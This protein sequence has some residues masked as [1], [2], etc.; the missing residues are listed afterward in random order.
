VVGSGFVVP[1]G[2][3]D[4]VSS[5]VVVGHGVRKFRSWLSVGR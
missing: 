3:F 5:A 4:E 1:F 2:G